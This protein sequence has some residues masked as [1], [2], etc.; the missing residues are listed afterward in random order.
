MPRA[1]GS[2]VRGRR[3]GL[4]TEEKRRPELGGLGAEH[5]HRRDPGAVHD[6][7]R[8]D[9]RHAQGADEAAGQREGPLLGIALLGGEKPAVTAGLHALPDDRVDADRFQTLSLVHGG[10][11]P[12]RVDAE[13]SAR[14]ES[15]RVDEPEGEAEHRGPGPQ[16]D[17][18]LLGKA[19]REGRAHGGI[20]QPQLRAVTA[21]RPHRTLDLVRRNGRLGRRREEV[22]R[23][24]PPGPR[25]DPGD[26][27][28]ELARAQVRG[29]E[30]AEP[31]G[32]A[33]RGDQLGSRRPTAERS[34]DQRPVKAE[35]LT[36][37][38]FQLSHPLLLPAGSRAG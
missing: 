6:P 29:T 32:L 3:A 2:A 11:R 28:L 25:P 26:R 12:D 10:R 23:E 9:H 19:R 36:P 35:R 30:G 38:C 33:D 27:G 16:H 24:G 37:R 22:D 8:G 4:V 34:Q 5:E 20:R 21:G 7:A 1:Q 15:R 31:A 17:R 14:G 13:L 18:H